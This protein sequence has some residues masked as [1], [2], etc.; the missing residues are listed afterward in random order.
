MHMRRSLALVIGALL[1]T[2]PLSSC[3]FD[4]ATNRVYTPAAGANDRDASV[5]VLNAVI[6]SAEEGSG[7]FIATFVNNDTEEPARVEAIQASGERQVT[8]EEFSPIEVDPIGMVNLAADDQDGIP[9]E[10]DLAAGQM[11]PLT[12]QLSG[13]QLVDLHIPVVPNCE[14][15]EGLDGVGGECELPEPEG[16]H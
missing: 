12:I 15:F 6:V 3:G 10:G 11:V 14:E 2:A 16:A 4:L 8:F 7:T 1:L 9:V 5:D 13:G